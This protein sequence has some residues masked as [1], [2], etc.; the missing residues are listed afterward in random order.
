MRV[1]FDRLTN[2]KDRDIVSVSV[3]VYIVTVYVMYV[4]AYT[5]YTYVLY[6]DCVYKYSN[7]YVHKYIHMYVS[8]Y[9]VYKLFVCMIY[10]Y[11]RG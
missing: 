7:T 2:D 8:F 4:R 10:I 6:G 1:F 5:M 3:Y 11:R 9:I